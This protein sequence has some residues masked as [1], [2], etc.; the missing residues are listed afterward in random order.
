V[1]G[2][3][4]SSLGFVEG[5]ILDVYVIDYEAAVWIKTLGGE[6]VR[7]VDEYRPEVLVEPRDAGA[8]EELLRLAAASPLVRRVEVVEGTVGL[9]ER[10]RRRLVRIEAYGARSVDR[11]SR[12]VR[13][14]GLASWVYGG[15]LP[16]V[17]RYL[18]KGLRIEPSSRVRIETSGDRIVS[19]ERLDDSCELRP[20]PFTLL[21]VFS[22]GTGS[23]VESLRLVAAGRSWRLEGPPRRLLGGFVDELQSI[24]PDLIYIPGLDGGVGGLLSS[25]RASGIR[26][27]VG[28]CG[29]P[30]RLSQGSAAG[31]IFLG[32]VYYGFEPDEYGVAGLVE[33]ARFSFTTLGLATR[34]TSNRC[35]DSRNLFELSRQGVLAPRLEY[36]EGVRRMVELLDRDRGGLSVTPSPGLHENVAALDFDSQYPSIIVK[37]GISYESPTGGGGIIPNILAQWLERRLRLKAVRRTLVPGSEEELYC[38]QRIEALKLILCTQYGISGCCWNRFGNTLAF[39]EI[40]SASRGALIR[41][42]R[43]AE[44]EGFEVVYGDVDSLFVKRRGASRRDYERLAS[45]ISSETGL[46]MSLDR[47]FRF[48]AFP[49]LRTDPDS[50]ALKRY[51]GLTY[52]G[53]VEARGIEMRRGDTPPL[54]REFQEN[55]VRTVFSAGSAEEVLTRGV[56]EGVRLLAAYEKLLEQPIPVEELEIKKR[57]GREPWGYGR[58]LAQ[59]SAAL[60]L[61]A[62]GVEAGR[63]VEVGYIYT[64]RSNPNPLLRVRATQ[65]FTGLYDKGYYRECLRRAAATVL[66]ALG[67]RVSEPPRDHRLETWL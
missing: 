30:W 31:R 57:L 9:R 66:E 67:A 29:D 48:I 39:E 25:L 17:Q 53:A 37:N 32:D 35:I 49:R 26:E 23:S 64:S 19:A 45:L 38:T 65:L 33:R 63:G 34:W 5:W 18:F 52:E 47:H 42:K 61:R 44:G 3:G 24:D 20:P 8:E 7:L 14:S 36:M 4:R 6:A 1:G 60:Q 62:L 51:F 21:R 22:R 58:M 15:E 28:R 46:P 2:G 16:H 11:V 54:V 12:A 10:S 56:E 41:A 27:D 55:L 50:P 43:I 59:S 40:N 13:R